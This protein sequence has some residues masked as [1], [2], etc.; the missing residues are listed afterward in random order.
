MTMATLYK[1]KHLIGALATVIEARSIIIVAE[2]T[3]SFTT[4][5]AENYILVQRQRET[6]FGRLKPLSSP[7]VT[8]FLQQG[9]T[10]YSF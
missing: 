1:D 4:T 6:G 5:V 2:N 9:H 7:L 8:C 3:M 10:S